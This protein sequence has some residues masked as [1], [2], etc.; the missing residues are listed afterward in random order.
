MRRR[1]VL[2]GLALAPLGVALGTSGAA[3]QGALQ[4]LQVAGTPTEDMTNLYYGLKT[5][6]FT[7]A[8]LDVELVPVSSGAATTQAVI[9]GTYELGKTSTLVVFAA[10]LRDIPIVI[11][12]PELV[13]QPSHP[14]A[15]VVVAADSSIKTGADLNGKTIAATALNDLNTLA[16]RAWVDK[17]GGDWKSLKFVEVPNAATEAAIAQHRVDASI[18]QTPQLDA[19][20]SNGTVRAIGD[21]WSAITP[22]FMVGVYIARKEWAD[23]HA[24]VLRRFNRAYIEATKYVNTHPAETLSYAVELTKIELD[25]AAK[26][27]RSQNGTVLVPATLQPVIDASVKYETLPRGFPARDI[28]WTG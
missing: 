28:V 27:R 15:M 26:M 10:H 24:D 11:V 18:L 23:A 14:F 2:S 20:L 19:A 8:G 5:G 3:A 7:R 17:N 16:M 1:E 12:A 9:A 25:K 4:K 13:N 6:A 21:A 22:N